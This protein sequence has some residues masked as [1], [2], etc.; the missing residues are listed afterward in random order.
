MI[1]AETYALIDRLAS[2]DWF[3]RLGHELPPLPVNTVAVPRRE[4]GRCLEDVDWQ[5]FTLMMKNSLVSNLGEAAYAKGESAGFD[6]ALNAT[7]VAIEKLFRAKIYVRIAAAAPL[8]SNDTLDRTVGKEIMC[9]LIEAQCARLLEGQCRFFMQL[10][11]PVYTAGHFPCG[12]RGEQI[13]EGW[14]G[15]NLRDLPTGHLMVC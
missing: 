9:M 8:V 6:E 14:Q 10:L 11:L 13:V 3:G 1:S 5:D 12:W 7:A 2:L 15:K 4:L